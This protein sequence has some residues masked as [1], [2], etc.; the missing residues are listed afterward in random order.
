[1]KKIFLFLIF[2]PNLIFTQNLFRNPSFESL[3][4]LAS[5]LFPPIIPIPDDEHQIPYCA[6]WTEDQSTQTSAIGVT[7]VVHSPD[8]YDTRAGFIRKLG[9]SNAHTGN[10]YVNMLVGEVIEQNLTLPLKP[11]K[12]YKISMFIQVIAS[13]AVL[14]NGQQSAIITPGAVGTNIKVLL[15]SSKIKYKNTSLDDPSVTNWL[16]KTKNPLLTV[17]IPTGNSPTLDWIEV[18]AEFTAPSIEQVSWV[19]IETD[20]CSLD[21]GASI[22]I[23][24]VKLEEIPISQSNCLK[25]KVEEGEIIST[26]SNFA[27]L[28]DVGAL[29]FNKVGNVKQIMV[30]QGFNVIGQNLGEM[31]FSVTNPECT[32]KWDGFIQ[33]TNTPFTTIAGTYFFDIEFVNDCGCKRITRQVEAVVSPQP[34]SLWVRSDNPSRPNKINPLVNCCREDLTLDLNTYDASVCRTLE[35]NFA[36]SGNQFHLQGPITFKSRN[37]ITVTSG[38][39]LK[40]AITF[41]AT[42]NIVISKGV[43]LIGPAM[44]FIGK[45][46]IIASG[47]L[48][49]G[50]D[51][52][53][54]IMPTDC[55]VQMMRSNETDDDITF[56]KMNNI[57]NKESALGF[58]LSPNPTNDVLTLNANNDISEGAIFSIYDLQG[59]VLTNRTVNTPTKNIYFDVS[60]YNK[61]IYFIKIT[62]KEFSET[63]KFIKQ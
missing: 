13:I 12:R 51:L 40:G 18:S 55:P 1:M 48:R 11:C 7:G 37:S 22:H 21:S 29:F 43:E 47:V 39:K 33:G 36:A 53:T 23:D 63:L 59:K 38:I 30:K 58:S 32:A 60:E 57:S 52:K 28:G 19:G 24:D 25:C 46:I 14:G 8:W 10:K 44:T 17:N 50:I 31:L 42:N 4:P 16:Q 35:Q 49:G 3:S 20:C 27:A 9:V 62:D 41:K 26:V 2:I 45:N 5:L 56:L 15:S 6:D 34:T 54:E 61:G